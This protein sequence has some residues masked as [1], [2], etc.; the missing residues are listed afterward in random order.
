MQMLK[1]SQDLMKRLVC[2]LNDKVN[3]L[4]ILALSEQARESIQALVWGSGDIEKRWMVN[5]RLECVCTPSCGLPL[6]YSK[7]DR[8]PNNRPEMIEWTSCDVT[9]PG[10]DGISTGPYPTGISTSAW[11]F[12]QGPWPF[13]C[14]KHGTD[15]ILCLESNSYHF[16]HL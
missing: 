16:R 11:Q 8:W 3:T 6:E 4:G 5:F 1:L 2:W 12:D 10:R 7:R 15:L 9:F 14:R 13:Q